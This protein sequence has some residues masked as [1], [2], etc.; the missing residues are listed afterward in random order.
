MPQVLDAIAH[1]RPVGLIYKCDLLQAASPAGNG[2]ALPVAR[3]R[4]KSPDSASFL[5]QV[6][7]QTGLGLY[8]KGTKVGIRFARLSTSAYVAEGTRVVVFRG[9][10]SIVDTDNL[11]RVW[12]GTFLL[13]QVEKVI[14][15]PVGVGGIQEVEWRFFEFAWGAQVAKSLF[16][17]AYGRRAD[18]LAWYGDDPC[19]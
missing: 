14:R 11:K 4:F 6:G 18:C 16:D 9:P 2:S 1:H 15:G 19:A 10:K 3:V 7:N 5:F 17:N 13:D 8:I 12:G